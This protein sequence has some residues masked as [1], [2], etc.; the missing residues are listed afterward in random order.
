MEVVGIGVKYG[1]KV[2]KNNHIT[3]IDEKW[4]SECGTSFVVNLL[5]HA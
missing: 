4:Q 3:G 1:R 5:I 2:R